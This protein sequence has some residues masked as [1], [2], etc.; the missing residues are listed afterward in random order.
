[1]PRQDRRR[2]ERRVVANG[3]TGRETTDLED[4]RDQAINELSEHRHRFFQRS[5]GDIVIMTA[6]R[7]YVPAT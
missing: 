1:M 3:A 4:Q 2:S 7:T 5:D 6:G